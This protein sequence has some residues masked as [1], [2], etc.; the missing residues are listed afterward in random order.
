VI[1][2]ITHTINPL[3]K[4]YYRSR[5]KHQM[6][7]GVHNSFSPIFNLRACFSC[8]W[9]KSP[10]VVPRIVYIA[11]MK[12]ET[13]KFAQPYTDLPPTAPP[14]SKPLAAFLVLLFP[15]L[16]PCLL[17]TGFSCRELDE[18]QCS[19][20]LNV[21]RSPDVALSCH[22]RDCLLCVLSLFHL[23]PNDQLV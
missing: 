22:E 3:T 7:Q 13:F 11:S 17:C 6:P 20:E 19:T 21:P 18:I 16:P 12:P 1:S 10:W 23:S 8:W 15:T 2:G 4:G 14:D 5:S 9:G